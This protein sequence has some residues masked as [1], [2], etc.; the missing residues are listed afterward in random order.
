VNGPANDVLYNVCFSENAKPINKEA[1]FAEPRFVGT[2]TDVFL[3]QA[4]PAAFQSWDEWTQEANRTAPDTIRTLK[5]YALAT[6][7]LTRLANLLEQPPTSGPP[8]GLLATL[9][10]ALRQE[11]PKY[12]GQRP[13]LLDDV[14]DL[15][16]LERTLGT[17]LLQS[18]QDHSVHYVHALE[19]LK[20]N[21]NVQIHQYV[22]VSAKKTVHF[23]APFKG[24]HGIYRDTRD[25]R[26]IFQ[27]EQK[28]VT[29]TLKTH[30][31]RIVRFGIDGAQCG[32]YFRNMGDMS[33]YGLQE[34]TH[35][36]EWK[37][38]SISGDFLSPLV[39]ENVETIAPDV[40]NT[41]KKSHVQLLKQFVV[42]F[43]ARHKKPYPNSDLQKLSQSIENMY[44]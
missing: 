15:S 3:R 9:W 18:I 11:Q 29:T 28:D 25:N 42:D 13:Y 21:N 43:I 32:T 4:Q 23:K 30:G 6:E 19:K 1:L 5:E 44:T 22:I 26:E 36:T 14:H 7:T 37:I 35:K 40:A 34:V 41:I 38:V 12:Q 2:I 20:N 17:F 33:L 16:I 8:P 31:Y 24:F 39:F 27:K 10:A